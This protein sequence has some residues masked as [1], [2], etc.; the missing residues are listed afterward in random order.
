MLEGKEP[1]ISDEP[2][3]PEGFEELERFV[4]DWA[5]PTTMERYSKRISTP[6][7]ELRVFYDAVLPRA[8]DA[9]ALLDEHEITELSGPQA[10]LMY[11]L[12]A[13]ID[14]SLPIE[15][16]KSPALRLAPAKERFLVSMDRM[17]FE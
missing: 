5:L 2:L 4:A 9:I 16:Y 15:V 7:D 14:V 17:T 11:L 10:R 3:L 12:L 1:M 8:S 6:M 13:L